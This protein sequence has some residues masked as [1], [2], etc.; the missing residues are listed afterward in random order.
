[1]KGRRILLNVVILVMLVCMAFVGRA[2]AVGTAFTYQGRLVDANSPAEGLYDFQFK[3]YR[4]TSQVG[5][6]INQSDVDV[7]DSYFT[8]ELDFGVNAFIGVKRW[9]EIGIRPGELEDP[10]DYTTLSPRQELTPTPHAL[11][12]AAAGSLNA[13][14]GDPAGVVYVD[15]TGKLLV[16]TTVPG[17]KLEV[18]GDQKIW[19]DLIVGSNVGIGT[20]S[21]TEALDVNGTAKA[22]AFVGDG[23]GLTNL[24][25]TPD[26]DWIESSG[27]VYRNS[28]RVGIGTAL[29]RGPLDV[30]GESQS[31]YLDVFSAKVYIGDVEGNGDETLLTVDDTS[32]KFT[33]ENGNVVIGNSSYDSKLA[34]HS[35]SGS[36]SIVGETATPTGG[37][38][39]V[40]GIA[41]GN[42]PDVSIGVAGSS[43]SATGKNYGIFGQAITASTDTNYGVMG[44]ASNAGSGDAYAGYFNGDGYFSGDVV[45]GNS[46]YDS[47]LAVHSDSGSQSIVGE[48]A[49]PTGGRHGVSGI[50]SGNNPDV[51]IG[52]A[53]SSFSA[54]GKNYGIFGQ[55]ITASTDTNYG[56]MGWASNAG[57]GDA[58]A[59]Y[60]SGDVYVSNSVG[61][62]TMTP[63][64][65]LDVNGDIRAIGSVYY[66]GTEGN[67]DGTVYNKPDYVFEEGYD[68]MSIE[69]VEEYLKKENHLPWMTSAKAEKQ[70]NGDVID[71]T[72]MAFETVETAENLQIQIIEQS[73]LIK[74]LKTQNESL[75]QRLSALES[76]ITQRPV[77][78]AREVQ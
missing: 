5:G 53:G 68:V 60:F 72:R 34:V 17:T 47:K 33:F 18:L 3:L 76:T 36:Q 1:M 27:N 69:Q 73:K 48:T 52:V 11:Y 31:V 8:V 24:P 38:H 37:R 25:V 28:G 65:D 7:V 2:G 63:A 61:I 39:G 15:E 22:T 41:S 62:G 71:M 55:A 50:A 51:S 77:S 45:I 21:P 66:G 6:D 32:N 42:N 30:R 43:F 12:A 23:S 49:T 75:N 58:Y 46:S 14:D 13:A 67:A 9:L 19:G 59:G 64:Y 70:E 56:V 10:N 40:S 29:P 74:E 16:G 4:S 35:D 54:T 26:T 57:S 20:T 78:M 44:W